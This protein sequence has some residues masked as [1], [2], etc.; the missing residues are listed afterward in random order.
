MELFEVD[1]WAEVPDFFLGA[2]VDSVVWDEDGD[3]DDALRTLSGSRK[4]A[5]YLAR[6]RCC[7]ISATTYGTGWPLAGSAGGR[8]V[9]QRADQRTAARQ[10]AHK[11]FTQVRAAARRKTLLLLWWIDGGM[12]VVVRST[13][14][15]QGSARGHSDYVRMVAW[16]H[17][18]CNLLTPPSGAMGLLL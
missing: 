2:M 18:L 13:L 3:E 8:R 1:G 15:R 4:R 10:R 12:N 5:P 16:V 6:Q 17:Q 7:E 11:Q 14:S 9:A